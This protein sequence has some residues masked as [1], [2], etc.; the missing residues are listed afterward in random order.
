MS[1]SGTDVKIGP[2]CTDLCP[3]FEKSCGRLAVATYARCEVRGEVRLRRREQNCSRAPAADE[4]GGRSGWAGTPT[5]D[6]VHAPLLPATDDT[7]SYQCGSGPA[8][9]SAPPG[10]P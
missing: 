4:A 2:I 9:L 1:M 3:P 10:D 8:T 7:P 6:G 5:G